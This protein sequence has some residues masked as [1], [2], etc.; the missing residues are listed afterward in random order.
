MASSEGGGRTPQSLQGVRKFFPL[1]TGQEP[2]FKEDIDWLKFS[3]TADRTGAYAAP[4][5]T[6]LVQFA[7][8]K[9]DEILL[10]LLAHL[11]RLYPEVYGPAV[12]TGWA[13]E[14][15]EF[16]I[17]E[18]E[19]LIGGTSVNSVKLRAYAGRFTNITLSGINNPIPNLTTV[20]L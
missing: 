10:E 5:P 18:G 7:V 15:R 6:V 14:R 3:Y 4:A 16:Q 13:P 12:A 17:G 8:A 1:L 9:G 20:Y 2:P 19:G 11:R